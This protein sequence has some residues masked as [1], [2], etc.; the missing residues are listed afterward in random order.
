[1]SDNEK[2]WALENTVKKEG[3]NSRSEKYEVIVIVKNESKI[4]IYAT[5][6]DSDR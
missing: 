6:I 5:V 1:M 2:D 3:M 4:K